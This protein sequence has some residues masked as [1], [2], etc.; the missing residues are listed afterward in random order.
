MDINKFH[1][2]VVSAPP[3]GL[4]VYHTGRLAED[5]GDTPVR[6]TPQW[7]LREVR[8]HAYSLWKEGR[9]FLLQRRVGKAFEYI[10][11]KAGGR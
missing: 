10:A 7:V 4:V 8:D 3:G 1:D 5:I 11:I 2:A 6:G 9:V